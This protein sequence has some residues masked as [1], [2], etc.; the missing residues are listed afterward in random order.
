MEA[1]GVTQVVKCFTSHEY[2][3]LDSQQVCTDCERRAIFRGEV[4]ERQIL[5]DYLPAHLAKNSELQAHQ[6]MLF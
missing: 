6:K 5:G 4:G 1:R 3:N 2:L